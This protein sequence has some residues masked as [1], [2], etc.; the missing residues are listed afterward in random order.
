MNAGSVGN[1]A[2]EI[3]EMVVDNFV[4][5]LSLPLLKHE[6]CRGYNTEE[7]CPTGCQLVHNPRDDDLGGGVGLLFKAGI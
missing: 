1:K 7:L 4:D 5:I 2:L 6:L 3:K